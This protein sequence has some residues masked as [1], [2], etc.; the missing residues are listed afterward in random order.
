M[1]CIMLLFIY[2]LFIYIIEEANKRKDFCTY[3][4]RL[5]AAHDI[6]KIYLIRLF[7]NAII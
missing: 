3:K 2:M 6:I 5:K 1:K 7:Y 4:S